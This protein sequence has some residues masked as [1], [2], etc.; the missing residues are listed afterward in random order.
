MTYGG[1]TEFERIMGEMGFGRVQIRTQ[2]RARQQQWQCEDGWIVGYTTSRI[3]GG[4]NDGKFAA[5]A[6][7][8]KGSGSRSGNPDHWERVY[9]RAFAKRTSARA[10]AEAL[11]WRHCPRRAAR[12]GKAPLKKDRG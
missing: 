3:A 5:M 12:V 1:L 10:R 2:A 9:Y 6:Y 8:P 7:K 11:Y 4:A